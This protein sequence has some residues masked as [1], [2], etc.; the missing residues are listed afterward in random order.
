MAC[1]RSE[2]GG[3]GWGSGHQAPAWRGCYQSQE[4]QAP[5]YR[6]ALGAF[7]TS[8]SA[9]RVGNAELTQVTQVRELTHGAEAAGMAILTSWQCNQARRPEL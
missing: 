5:G 3:L 2:L 7:L 9:A 6:R 4:R 8:S 1:C